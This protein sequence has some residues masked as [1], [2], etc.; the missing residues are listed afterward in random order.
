M[1]QQNI[2]FSCEKQTT[3]ITEQVVSEHVI[4]FVVSGKVEFQFNSETLSLFP[5]DIILIRK[6]QPVKA[7]KFPENQY[8]ACRT[9]NIFLTQEIIRNYATHN[10]VPQQPMYK[11]KPFISLG[12]DRFLKAYFASL[13][14]YIEHTERFT[15]KLL[16][17]KT[18]EIIELLLANRLEMQSFLFDFSEPYKI[19]LEKFMSNNYMFNLPLS[20]FSRL[21]GRSLS[22]FK[23]DFKKIYADT[24]ENWLRN[25]RLDEA[26]YLLTQKHKRPTDIYY[27]LGFESFSHFSAAYKQKFGTTPREGR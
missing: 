18:T 7:T 8:E 19:D 24:P 10:D 23:R 9:V 15:A 5:D 2:L 6:N 3:H 20:E 22:T 21:T 12:N 11:G 14:P 17:L 25:R 1:N 16:E 27:S 13:T 26:Q 4:T